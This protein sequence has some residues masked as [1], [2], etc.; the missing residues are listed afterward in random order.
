MYAKYIY[1]FNNLTLMPRND[2][3]A[4]KNEIFHFEALNVLVD[5]Y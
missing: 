1:K 4:V 5:I 3:F 2:Y